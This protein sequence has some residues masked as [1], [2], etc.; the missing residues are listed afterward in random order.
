MGHGGAPARLQ[1]GNPK[2]KRNAA[3]Y[4]VAPHGVPAALGAG[5]T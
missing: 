4:L 5:S 1:V 2:R 3:R